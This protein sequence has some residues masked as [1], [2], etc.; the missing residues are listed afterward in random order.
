MT[1]RFVNG[2]QAAA[3]LILQRTAP[4]D[5]PSL[6][7]DPQMPPPRSGD[8]Y[9]PIQ[10]LRTN[11]NILAISPQSFLSFRTPHPDVVLSSLWLRLTR[12]R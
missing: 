4:T 5:P 9:G 8:V 6:D 1:K 3:V 10:T 12:S 11:I 2:G 7:L